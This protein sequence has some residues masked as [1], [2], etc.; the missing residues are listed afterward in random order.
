MFVELLLTIKANVHEAC[1]E[2]IVRVLETL[3]DKMI[4][5]SVYLVGR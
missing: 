5:K 4:R 3:K 1:S 2:D